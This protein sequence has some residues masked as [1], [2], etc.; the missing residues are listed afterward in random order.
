MGHGGRK[1]IGIERNTPEQI[2]FKLRKAD[3]TLAQGQHVKDVCR[4]REG[5]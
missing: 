5:T 2:I 3:V 1:D 4:Q